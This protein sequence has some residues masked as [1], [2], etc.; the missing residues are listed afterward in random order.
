MTID[1]I[2]KEVTLEDLEGE[3]K[4]I[5]TEIGLENMKR[6]S[7]KFGGSRIYIPQPNGLASNAIQRMVKEDSKKLSTRQ[8]A[9]KYNIGERTVTKYR[10]R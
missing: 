7:M 3:P 6:L 1:D 4:R 8:T 9:Q 2:L 10:N 5:A